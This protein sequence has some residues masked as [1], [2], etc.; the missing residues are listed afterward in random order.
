MSHVGVSRSSCAASPFVRARASE[1]DK[2]P[3]RRLPFPA[4]AGAFLPDVTLRTDF[5]ET[6]SP[7]ARFKLAH[8]IVSKIRS[9]FSSPRPGRAREIS[10]SRFASKRREETFLAGRA[11]GKRK[12]WTRRALTGKSDAP[13]VKSRAFTGAIAPVTTFGRFRLDPSRLARVSQD[14][15][16]SL[17]C[18]PKKKRRKVSRASKKSLSRRAF[19]R[20]RLASPPPRLS[21]SPFFVREEEDPHKRS[22]PRPSKRRYGYPSP[23][24][25]CVCSASPRAR[26]FAEAS[27]NGENP[28]R[29]FQSGTTD[30]SATSW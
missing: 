2:E 19:R 23:P 6:A 5:F 10:C 29:R 7:Y 15:S 30:T 13:P 21:R 3:R 27:S 16:L 20:R 4:T 9:R 8:R 26:A 18:F 24:V 25:V 17:N 14:F 11:V 12:K 22:L 28:R 1:G